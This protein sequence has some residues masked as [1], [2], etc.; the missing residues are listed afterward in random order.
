MKQILMSDADMS[1][2][3]LASGRYAGTESDSV[4]LRYVSLRSRFPRGAKVYSLCSF[5][6]RSRKLWSELGEIF[7]GQLRVGMGRLALAMIGNLR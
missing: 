1:A 5:A 6:C 2:N 3:T 7:S 4:L